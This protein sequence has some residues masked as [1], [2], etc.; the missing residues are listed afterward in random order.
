[1]RID[2]VLF[3][4][5]LAGRNLDSFLFV[6]ITKNATVNIHVKAY[7]FLCGRIVSFFLGVDPRV[8][9]LNHMVTLCL[10]FWETSKL[11]SKV[12]ALFYSPTA[13]AW[14]FAVSLPYQ[15]LFVSF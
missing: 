6:V 14:G 4:Q 7:K 15:H 5:S 3:I 13:S 10:T 2:N 1:M 11:F 9:L 12:A 8:E